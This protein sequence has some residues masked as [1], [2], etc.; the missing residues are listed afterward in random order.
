M[1]NVSALIDG[2]RNSRK[3]KSYL[4]LQL[5]ILG[6]VILLLVNLNQLQN[7]T[8]TANFSLY[9]TQL[10]NLSIPADKQILIIEI[11]EQSL[12]LIGEW[13][14]PRSYHG[15]LIQ[16]LTQAEVD[17]IAYNVV[18][19]RSNL[20][21]RNDVALAKAIEDSGRTILP[22]YF[23]R[24]TRSGEVSEVLPADSFRNHAGL[25]H[26]NSYLD[27]DGTLRSIRLIDRFSD[28]QWP[29]FSMASFLFN[30]PYSTVFDKIGANV[31]IPFVNK[32]DF[33]RVSFVDVLTGLVPVEV[34]AQR[35]VFVGMTA[36]SMG[37][38][39]LTPVDDNGRQSP[40]VDI[41][42][43]VY[44]AL[45]HDSLILPLPTIASAA[46]NSFMIL[47]AL[48][49]IP[50]LSGVQQIIMTA[51]CFVAVWFIT[52]GLLL[53]G[54]WYASA[55][56]MMALLVIPFIW[57]L[58]RL[59]RLFHYLRMQIK[60]LKQQQLSEVF[61]LPEF[62]QMS[63]EKD[64]KSIMVLMQLD[65]YQLKSRAAVNP[66]PMLSVV[67]SLAIRIGKKKKL[68]VIHFDKF[69]D[70]EK[71]KLNLLSQL[72]GSEYSQF[73]SVDNENNA[74]VRS[75]MFSQQLSLV[76]S[77]Q[78]QMAMSHSMFEA[79]IEGIAAGILVT[80]LA[81]K[82]LFSNKVV[83]EITHNKIA[84][85]D[86][87]FSS[88]SLLESDWITVL[89]ETILLQQ[90][91][92][93]EAKSKQVDLS[94]S[95]RCI[96]SQENLAPLLV[97][98][99]TDVSAI[100]QAHRSRNEMIDFLSHDLRSPMASLQALV[101]QVRGSTEQESSVNIDIINKVDQYSR[102]GLNFAE[103]FLNL[104]KVESEE[105]IQLYEVD[106]YSISQNALDSLY[107]QAQEK[108]IK[109]S[110]SV[111]DECWVM[112]NGDLLERIILNLVTNA[113][114][115]SPSGSEVSV[116]IHQQ[117]PINSSKSLE[118]RITDQGPG[119]P[120]ELRDGLFKPFQR[121]T[122]K[123]TQQAQGVGLGLRFVDVA[124]KRLGSKI[125]FDTSPSGSSF[126][127]ILESID[128]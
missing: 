87:L 24:L 2:F 126:Y 64:L 102:R 18:F 103:Q 22:L 95:I 112:A 36:T 81:G 128:L 67:K 62:I 31:F 35:T 9:D 38:P 25:G 48:Y 37:D 4:D 115:Y 100:K 15:Q 101:E 39:L 46:I 66:A 109:L 43:N 33:D 23:D 29:H 127:F 107:H 32:G 10:K 54:Y 118:V 58:L 26:V 68:L 94:V 125:E 71:R 5:I 49:L 78:K 59:S 55:G 104:A 72:L 97:F 99:L 41:N 70:L 14:W 92:T 79:S 20:N 69:T 88:V 85:L 51:V 98:N 12:S 44:Q 124:L 56:L 3:I 123:N 84:N 86:D 111:V 96:E 65:H 117:E 1:A 11:D 57:N 16:L 90:P 34:L 17:V 122:D 27:S 6:L 40:A 13:P 89:R 47:L 93:V 77:Y 21:D 53:L 116:S 108:L 83:K 7:W 74:Q 75:D 80:D 28:R 52:Y 114:K 121:G 42:A 91:M 50:R 63:S 60:G 76:E 45:K 113:I 105:M 119:I 106:L 110:L 120:I 30:Q 82:V 8:Q 73:P 19:F 61:H